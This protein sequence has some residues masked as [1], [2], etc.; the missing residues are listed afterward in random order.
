MPRINAVN[1]FRE[2][3]EINDPKARMPLTGIGLAW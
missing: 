2:I 3:E 1:L